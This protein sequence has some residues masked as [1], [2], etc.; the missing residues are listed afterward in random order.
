MLHLSFLEMVLVQNSLNR[1]HTALL[2]LG[3]VLGGCQGYQPQ[4]L[5]PDEHRRAWLERS[6]RS[7]GVLQL[8]ER[9]TEQS[10]PTTAY[11]PEDGISLAEAEIIAL[12]FNPELRLARLRAGIAAATAENAGLW[13]DP[14]FSIDVLRVTEGVANP[15]VI[16]PGLAFTIPISG[17]LEVEKA[18]ADATLR[19]ELTKV[20][21]AE[22]LVRH[23]VRRAWLAWSAALLATEEIGTLIDAMQGLTESTARLAR[24]GELPRTEAALF[25]IEQSQRQQERRRLEGATAVAE[26]HLRMLLGL[27]PDAPLELVPSMEIL[28]PA[29]IE[30]DLLASSLQLRRLREAYEVAEHNLHREVR[31]QYPDLTIGPLY[32]TDQG[33]SR[34]GFL[35]AIPLPILNANREG[36]ARANAERELA[37]ASFETALER[38]EGSLAIARVRAAALGAEYEELV[39]VVGPMIDRQVVDAIKLVELGEAGESGGLVLLDGLVRSYDTKLNMIDL[40]RDLALATTHIDYL[41][42]PGR[43]STGS[44][45]T[46]EDASEGEVTP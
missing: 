36:I 13:E 20:A 31:K 41:V 12:V 10:V 32:E 34:I 1:G 44:T 28:E 43:G 17:R 33:Q 9:L 30:V 25:L 7:D 42:G 45:N 22:W 23:D 4:P 26:Q 8:S 19:T 14:V 35:G 29:E 27:S 38:L 21:E 3:L 11:D 6:P 5:Q 39:S 15:W 24:A 18:Q 2:F 40:R 16:M 37:R 46:P